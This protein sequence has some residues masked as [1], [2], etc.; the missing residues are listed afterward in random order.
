VSDW[1][2]RQRG[3]ALGIANSGIGI[4]GFVTP[5]LAQYLI[6]RTGWRG[7]YMG[8]AAGCLVIAVPSVWMFLRRPPDGGVL[9]RSG[10]PADVRT[11]G[12]QHSAGLG[13]KQALRTKTFWQL[14]IIVFCLGLGINGASAHLA[15]LL[16]DAGTSGQSAALAASIFGGTIIIGRLTA[17][18]LLDQFFAP[19][20]AA[21]LFGGSALGMALLWCGASGK[22]AFLAASLLGI[23]AGAEG[24]FMPF[25]ISRYFGMR[26][27]AELYGWIFGVFTLGNAAGRYMLGAGFDTFGS[28]KV[29]LLLAFSAIVIAVVT[30]VL[31]GSYRAYGPE[32]V[33]AI[34]FSE[35]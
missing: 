19:R 33:S 26:S 35:A 14:A 15:P 29:P 4:G 9:P 7:A 17:G 6:E 27:M 12:Q 20:V 32:R 34:R 10:C 11:Q 3:L 8:L 25:L 5:L 24:D 23:G 13:L 2:D 21:I 22:T 28:Y 31:L 18:Y 1:F 30:C 16:A